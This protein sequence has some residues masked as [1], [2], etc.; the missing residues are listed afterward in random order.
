[1]SRQAALLGS[2]AVHVWYLP[3]ESLTSRELRDDL[4][5]LL[6]AEERARAGRFHF[7]RDRRIF[8]SSRALLRRALSQYDPTVPHDWKFWTNRYGKP[9][10]TSASAESPVLQFNVTHTQGLVAVAV[11]RGRQVGIDAEHLDRA[12]AWSNLAPTVFA[13]QEVAQLESLREEERP[14]AF[15]RFWTLKEAFVK[16]RGQGLSLNLKD[17][18]FVLDTGARPRIEFAAPLADQSERWQFFLFD[19]FPNHQLALAVEGQQD[20]TVAFF[21]GADLWSPGR[22]G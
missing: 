7:E 16:A 15:F 11:T 3:P 13:P 12:V 8:I 18:R 21:A 2:Q 14:A 4:D 20:I 1:V 6:D 9:Y 19:C 10:L 22:E 5:G 17:F